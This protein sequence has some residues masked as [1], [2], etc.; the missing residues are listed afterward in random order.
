MFKVIGII[1]DNPG[2][3]AYNAVQFAV[4]GQSEE[5]IRDKLAQLK[6]NLDEMDVIFVE[7]GKLYDYY[8]PILTSKKNK[9]IDPVEFLHRM[10]KIAR[11]DDT[12]KVHGDGDELLCEMLE[13]VKPELGAGIMVYKAMEKW[14]A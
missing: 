11:Q 12:K 13:N 10:I 1:K 7:D 2:E 3:F 8:L 4:G 14:Y 9:D 5:E 6:L